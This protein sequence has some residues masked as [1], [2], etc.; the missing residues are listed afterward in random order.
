MLPPICQIRYLPATYACP[1]PVPSQVNGA[2]CFLPEDKVLALVPLID[3]EGWRKA[4]DSVPGEQL[5]QASVTWAY[6]V[7]QDRNAS[8]KCVGSIHLVDE[9]CPLGTVAG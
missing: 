4:T 3:Y 8:F 2:R 6:Q 9:W 7:L 1:S 5:V